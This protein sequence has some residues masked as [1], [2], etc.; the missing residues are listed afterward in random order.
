MAFCEKLPQVWPLTTRE[1]IV[2]VNERKTI[3]G[4]CALTEN[5]LDCFFF[6]QVFHELI[7]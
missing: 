3:R 7:K 6:L 1:D 2:E 5:T 4:L